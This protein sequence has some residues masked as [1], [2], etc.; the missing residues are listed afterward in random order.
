MNTLRLKLLIVTIFAFAA[1]FMSGMRSELTANAE[2][3]VSDDLEAF[4]KTKCAMC[5]GPKAVK[6]FDT[7]L[8]DE[9]LVRAILDGKK[10]EKPPHM[11]AYRDKG[12]DEEKAQALVTFMRQLKT[13]PAE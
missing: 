5:H 13:P 7:E 6:A 12:V 10:A 11:P 1:L 9:E 2:P 3:A 4:Y 8:S